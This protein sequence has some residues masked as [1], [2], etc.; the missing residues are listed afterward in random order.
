MDSRLGLI[1]V[2]AAMHSPSGTTVNSR[3]SGA[4][5][6]RTDEAAG[7]TQR[8][9]LVRLSPV[10]VRLPLLAELA[11]SRKPLRRVPRRGRVLP[12]NALTAPLC[13]GLLPGNR[14]KARP[15]MSVPARSLSRSPGFPACRVRSACCRFPRCGHA[16]LEAK[17][18]AGAARRQSRQVHPQTLCQV[19]IQRELLCH[20]P[21]ALIARPQ[22]TIGCQQ[23][24]RE[25][26]RIQVA[27]SAPE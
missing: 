21:Q 8:S 5:P 3:H 10:R 18:R 17:G 25:K 15:A 7:V 20:G 6:D 26:M 1:V 27:D 11:G 24:S 13:S 12:R 23:D 9:G 14:L 19:S 22:A 2:S 4:Q 16:G